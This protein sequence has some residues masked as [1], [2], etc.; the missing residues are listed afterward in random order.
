MM[1]NNRSFSLPLYRLSWG[2]ARRRARRTSPWTCAG[3]E[4]ADARG[5]SFSKLAGREELTDPFQVPSLARPLL[6]SGLMGR[7]VGLKTEAIRKKK[8]C[9]ILWKDLC[10]FQRLILTCFA[11]ISTHPASSEMFRKVECWQST[12]TLGCR[13]AREGPTLQNSP[14]D[15]TIWSIGSTGLYDAKPALNPRQT[16]KKSILRV[17][18]YG[19]RWQRRVQMPRAAYSTGE[20]RWCR[21]ER[22]SRICL[23][24]VAGVRRLLGLFGDLE[25]GADQRVPQLID[26]SIRDGWACQQ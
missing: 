9:H 2:R 6:L 21:E 13:S 11:V 10:V 20:G 15:L 19:E 16:S 7:N 22:G 17:N 14:A 26:G 1:Q 3:T 12:R 24:G 5:P 18:L 25:N 8:R 4:A 23:S